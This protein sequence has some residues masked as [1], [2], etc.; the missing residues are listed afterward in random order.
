[1]IYGPKYTVAV[2]YAPPGQGFH[3]LRADGGYHECVQPGA[4]RSIQGAAE[5]PARRRV[6][7]E[8]L[9]PALRLVVRS[10]ALARRDSKLPQSVTQESSHVK[11]PVVDPRPGGLSPDP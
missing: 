7:G 1:M 9:D 3:L 5:C 4:C 8:L 11:Q 6:A 2:V 10:R